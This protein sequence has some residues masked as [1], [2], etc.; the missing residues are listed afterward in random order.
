MYLVVWT[1]DSAGVWAFS[2][3]FVTIVGLLMWALKRYI[4]KN[5]NKHDATVKSIFELTSTMKTHL[6]VSKT[7]EENRNK[8]F[9]RVNAHINTLYTRTDEN[10]K[11]IAV[12]K[13]KIK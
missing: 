9:D 6:E 5:D 11:D 10:T 8:H 13:S 12:I 2:F 7:E 3:V 4:D 1:L